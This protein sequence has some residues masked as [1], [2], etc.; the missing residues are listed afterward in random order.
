MDPHS[1]TSLQSVRHTGMSGAH[2]AI[3]DGENQ[4]AAAGQVRSGCF[5]LCHSWNML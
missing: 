1:L 3:S 2:G 4:P 5:C